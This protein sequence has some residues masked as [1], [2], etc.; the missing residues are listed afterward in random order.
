M[1][2]VQAVRLKSAGCSFFKVVEMM[3]IELQIGQ[4]QK[5]VELKAVS[6]LGTNGIL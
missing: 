2:R 4:L 1:K 6:Q 3:T 5:D